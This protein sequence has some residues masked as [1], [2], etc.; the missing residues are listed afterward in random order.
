M[1]V[2]PIPIFT[3]AEAKGDQSRKA[4]DEHGFIVVREVFSGE[5][6]AQLGKTF[7][8]KVEQ[9]NTFAVID[10]HIS[11]DDILGKYPRFVQPHRWPD[12]PPGASAKRLMLDTRLVDISSNLIG[13]VLAAQSM[14]HFKPPTARGQ[15][16][17][18]DDF[19]LG[20]S[21]GPC[22]AAWVAVDDADAKNGAIE[23]VPGSHR[24]DITCHEQADMSV[25]YAS[26]AMP[27]PPNTETIMAVLKAGDVLFFNGHVVHG[28]KPNSTTDR[29]RRALI[30]HYVPENSEKIHEF[31]QPLVKPSGEEVYV[32][33]DV[34][35]G[36][37]GAEAEI[38]RT[39][40]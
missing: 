12:T 27:L 3:A 22:L 34:G 32:G 24:F 26:R 10:H 36:P 29:F 6:M 14:F 19:F 5:E 15:A 37:C 13:P 7:L 2:Y 4:F 35:E 8:D 33:Q 1:T 28:S 23:V 30:Y 31:F 25:S 20:T 39:G 21:P 40:A 9:D 38:D 11:P 17:H 18:Q 16:M